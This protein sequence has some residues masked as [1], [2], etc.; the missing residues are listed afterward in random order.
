MKPQTIGL[1]IA[2]TVTGAFLL[3]V[4]VV[5]FWQYTESHPRPNHR[6]RAALHFNQNVQVAPA[7]DFQMP[8]AP[9]V[10][11]E[12]L[13]LNKA[14]LPHIRGVAVAA[15][16][17][18]LSGPHAHGNLAIFL[19]HG[20]DT[21]QTPILTLQEGIEQKAVV[22]RQ[23]QGHLLAIDNRGGAPLFI[24]SGDIVKGGTQDRVLP[25][26]LLVSA[27]STGTI[28]ALCVEAGRSI[29]RGNESSTSFGS[30]TEQ[31][32]TRSLK[33]AAQRRSQQEV[34][35]NVQTLQTNLARNTGG[36][37][38]AQQSQT[39]LQL[40]LEHHR[41][42]DAVQAYLT[43]LGPVLEGKK[44]AIGFAVVVNG[45]VQSADVYASSGLFVKLW[46][47][48]LRA[49][50]VEALAER[51]A[52]AVFAVPAEDTVQ[53]FLANA[54]QGLPS[55]VQSGGRSVT[56]RHNAGPTMLLDTC[57]SAQQNV[58]LHRSYLAK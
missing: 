51:Q 1:T 33:L 37:V 18:K 25:N 40:S 41:V 31:L 23:T 55:R 17:Y 45:K 26:D 12:P 39:S 47:K 14:E 57:D 35:N 3:A 22:V 27:N 24:Q 10:I 6:Q 15:K 29:Q 8:D 43:P 9:L 46:P 56:I 49:S 42:Q 38:Q 13:I 50:A 5:S 44:D 34:W 54:E 28:V 21:I 30:A 53:A 11:D 16:D 52:S 32:P 20:A 4:G 7:P 58:V 19:I 36:S 2:A 48:L